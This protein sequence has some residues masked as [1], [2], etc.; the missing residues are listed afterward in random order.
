MSNQPA[1]VGIPADFRP[2]GVGRHVTDDT[3]VR[4][5][6]EQIG[7]VPVVLPALEDKVD[8]SAVLERLDGIVFPG[9][10]SN[11]AAARYGAEEQIP[12]GPQDLKRDASNMPLIPRA[13]ERGIPLL[14]ICRGL[15]ELNVAYGG[16]LHQKLHELP[17]RIDHREPESPSIDE[18]FALAHTVT[19]ADGGLLK[20]LAGGAT[21][22]VNS[23]HWQG[24]DRLGNGLVVEAVAPDGTIEAV[25]VE[26][27][28]A[29]ALA[30]QWHPE[31][32]PSENALYAAI[33]AAFGRAVKQR[34]G[35]KGP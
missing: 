35:R 32:R 24:I 22:E 25:R 11:V 17:G 30:V 9:A 28:P 12:G 3:Y 8:L 6:V 27:A 33:W 34:A 19:F 5:V 20:D 26:D 7:A 23:L 16:S 29:F 31:H 14:A 10:E 4:A 15:Q 18:Q 21:A 1:L 13:V 2:R